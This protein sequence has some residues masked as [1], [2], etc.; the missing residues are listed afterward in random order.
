MTPR[1]AQVALACFV[2]LATGV[3]Y[4]ALYMQGDAADSRKVGSATSAKPP[5]DH[6]RRAQTAK[7]G[8]PPAE[9]GK[10]TALK[11][12]ASKSDIVTG[13]L[14]DEAGADTIRG[15]QRELVQRGLGPVAVD[16]VMRPATRAAILAYE[17]DNRLPLTGEA[18]DPLLRGLLLGAPS[19]QVTGARE[20]R[21]SHAEDMI[22]QVQ[23]LLAAKGYRP[24]PIDGRLSAETVEAIRSFEQAQGLVPAKGRVSAEVYVRLQDSAKLKSAEA[25]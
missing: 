7:P 21:S 6:A 3:T 1:Q 23:R 16:G 22:K 4:N 24:G 11:P 2:L 12:G 13:A 17:Y 18:T 9:T 10:R 14:P 25:R 20:V 19:A 8:T 5:E 15:I